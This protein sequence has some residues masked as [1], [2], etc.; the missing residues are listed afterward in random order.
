MGNI[1]RRL[2]ASLFPQQREAK[3]VM[4]G[5]DSAGKT[6]I[7]YQLQIGQVVS[8]VPTIGFNIETVKHGNISFVVWDAGGQ[9]R[10]RELW[11][12]YY[13]HADGVIWV[14]DAS[15]EER[16]IESCEILRGVLEEPE[17]KD[18]AL[19]VL[20]NKQ[21]MTEAKSGGELAQMLVKQNVLKETELAERR[22]Q[23]HESCGLTG[24]G[25]AE[26]LEWLAK[27]AS[28]SSKSNKDSKS[29]T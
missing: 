15:D 20:A 26:G 25:L 2:L 4:I 21:D 5:L 19:L 9:Y 3:I 12:H 11:K 6:T 28:S 1:F 10:I 23:V 29:S 14:V 17:L 7:L 16:L 27:N 8:T 18:V 22:W 24:D 13:S